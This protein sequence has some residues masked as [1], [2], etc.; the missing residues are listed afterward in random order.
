MLS[1][2]LIRSTEQ[3]TPSIGKLSGH[4][5]QLLELCG[6][7]TVVAEKLISVLDRLTAQKT[8]S[9]WDSFGRALLTVWNSKEIELLEKELQS[10]RQQI[11]LY[12]NV[13]VR[14]QVNH[15]QADQSSHGQLIS[16]SLQVTQD[17]TQHILKQMDQTARWQA[18]LIEAINRSSN[19]NDKQI[20]GLNAS[21]INTHNQFYEK[22][23]ER[24]RKRLIAHL[25]Y[26]NMETR[27]ES[28]PDAYGETFQWI[29]SK[30]DLKWS[31]FVHFLESDQSLYW[32]TGKP[33]SGKS[34]L[35][36]HIKNDERTKRCLSAW[37]GGKKIY[38]TGFY[39]G[40]PEATK[41]R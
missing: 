18:K 22:H 27:S 30:P 9:F 6:N 36:K 23:A 37:S 3:A 38:L 41:S 17:L 35:M 7:C 26:I 31:D 15:I 8:H 1:D 11:S 24:F 33:G 10:Y 25:H 13:S 14:K 29:F 19:R 5:A 34:T 40:V 32:I 2:D 21:P 12:Y 20:L 39:F 4:D 28:V 16:T